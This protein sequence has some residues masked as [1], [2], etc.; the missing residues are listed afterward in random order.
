MTEIR[1]FTEEHVGDVATLFLRAMRGRR[2]APGAAL[3]DYFGE[4]FFANPWAAADLPSL[5]YLS[6]SAVVGFLGVIPRP[7]EFRGRRIR[8]AVATQFMIDRERYRGPAA[9]E[10]LKRYFAGPQD[11][12]FTDGAAE[13]TLAL[14]SAAGGWGAPLYSFN[15]LRPLRLLGTARGFASRATGLAGRAARLGM[16][17]AAPL[18]F[19]LS[20]GP[21][22]SLRR[23]VSS[24]V[25]KPADAARLFEATQEIPARDP[26]RP[27]YDQ[28]SFAWLLAQAAR[29]RCNGEL[30]MATVHTP[31]G[32]LCGWYICHAQRRG[33]ASLLQI[34]VRR[35][36]QFDAVLRAFFRDAWEQ[37]CSFAKGQALPHF[38]VN[39]S[40]EYCLFR[41]ANTSTLFHTRD[42]ELKETI[43]SGQAALSRLD[44]ECW[45]RF[46]V[47][48]WK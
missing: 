28:L 40:R 13:A 33:A 16:T 30:R 42:G 18:D 9:F 25:S 12:S 19:V 1:A 5:V 23:P 6:G 3:R 15:W 45:L 4:I 32:D 46:A 44:G 7:M 29:V 20:H 11:L 43:L 14:W 10:L 22:E 37:G 31:D 2:E 47:E 17:V 41:M 36:D 8:A 38:L 27:A 24:C 35:R 21:H 34:G 48:D 39:L 26:L